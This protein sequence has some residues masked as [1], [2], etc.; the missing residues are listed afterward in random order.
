MEITE[1]V[2]ARIAEDEEA[3]RDAALSAGGIG[4]GEER[5]S[6]GKTWDRRYHEV[7]RPVTDVTDRRTIADCNGFAGLSIAPHIARWDPA[8]VLAECGAK[9]LV[10]EAAWNDQLRIEGEW[11]SGQ[12]REQMEAD[13]ARLHAKGLWATLQQD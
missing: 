4:Y 11:G 7:V 9:R 12:S 3:A 1:F 6:N 13:V 5:I 10:I 8:R 2:L